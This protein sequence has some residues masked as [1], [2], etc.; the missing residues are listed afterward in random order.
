MLLDALDFTVQLVSVNM[1]SFAVT[2]SKNTDN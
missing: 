1:Q 2:S